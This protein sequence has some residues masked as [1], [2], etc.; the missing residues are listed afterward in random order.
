LAGRGSVWIGAF[1]ECVV[2]Y[3]PLAWQFFPH[4]QDAED[5]EFDSFKEAL[6]GR[7][8]DAE[9][10]VLCLN[11]VVGAWGFAVFRS[12][13]SIRR[14]HGYDGMVICDEGERLPIEKEFLARFQRVE[15]AGETRYRDTNH[16][17]EGDVTDADF[18]EHLTSAIFESF[19][20]ESVDAVKKFN[21]DGVSFWLSK[22]EEQRYS[23]TFTAEPAPVSRPWWK[24]WG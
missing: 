13:Q 8:A 22:A 18:G 20:G 14:S 7:F 12:G 9:V 6:L 17:D 19:T 5:A 4:E 16:S 15:L 21:P 1:G 10:T 23:R 11:G 2:I 3:A 24:F